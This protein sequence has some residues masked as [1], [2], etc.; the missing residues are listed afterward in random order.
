MFHCLAAAQTNG[1]ARRLHSQ[2]AT[3]RRADM[4]AAVNRSRNIVMPII[5]GRT[6][7]K[8][9]VRFSTR[10]EYENNET[11]YA[12]LHFIGE[13]SEYLMNQLVDTGARA[14]F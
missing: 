12:Y 8:H 9:F 13:P 7:G 6:R 3:R 10:L 5:S 2:Q 4:R 1:L 14:G 11:Y